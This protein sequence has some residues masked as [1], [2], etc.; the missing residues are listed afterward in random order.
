MVNITLYKNKAERHRVNKTDYLTEVASVTGTFTED[1]SVT[2]PTLLLKYN[3]VPDFNYILIKELQRYYFVT[4]YTHRANNLWEIYLEVDVLMSYKSGIY[5]LKA[6]VDRCENHRDDMIIDNKRTVR[7]GYDVKEY[8]I[9]NDVFVEPN[10]YSPQYILTGFNVKKHPQTL[11]G[12]FSID[13]DDYYSPTIG[14][15][16][17]SVTWRE[18]VYSSYNTIGLYISDDGYVTT[19]DGHRIYTGNDVTAYEIATD[20]IIVGTNYYTN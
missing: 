11:V 6:F 1:V 4:D 20:N 16:T 19:S 17:T 15:D 8:T 5:Q 12:I 9:E 3:S 10:F 14:L 2:S 7:Q 18:W 13:G